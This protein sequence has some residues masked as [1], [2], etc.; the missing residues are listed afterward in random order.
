VAACI[1]LVAR[2]L[3]VAGACARLAARVAALVCAPSAPALESVHTEAAG[4]AAAADIGGEGGGSG[5]A[6]R[7]P[8]SESTQAAAIGTVEKLAMALPIA[9]TTL[10][11]SAGNHI[12][13]RRHEGPLCGPSCSMRRCKGRPCRAEKMQ[14]VRSLV[15]RKA[16][17][18]LTGIARL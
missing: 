16:S 10:T 6:L 12:F 8:A 14:L 9:A 11:I 2:V 7:S 17:I 3:S 18:V 4:G 5:T 1:H 13:P 15:K